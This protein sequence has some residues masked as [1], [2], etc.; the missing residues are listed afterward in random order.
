[1]NGLGFLEH[2]G[3]D[4]VQFVDLPEPV[5]GPGEVRVR[6]KAASFNHLDLFTLEGI[7]GVD[8][9]RPHVLGSD[10][11]GVVDRLG[12]GSD[13]PTEGSRVLLNPGLWDG[14]CEACRKGEES[15]C[16]NY[17]ILGEHTQGTATDLVVVPERNV[18]PI[19]ER[20]TFEQASAAPLVF[21]TAWRA[22][23]TVAR[24]VPGESC[25]IIGAGG[26]VSTAAVQVAR[27]LGARVVVATRSEEKA[28]QVRRQGGAEALVFGPEAP[29]ERV[30][31][32]WSEKKGVD[33]IFDS[34]GQPTVGRSLLATARSGRI[35][36]VGATAG[37]K[38]EIDLRTL[39][40][41]QASLRGSTMA[42]AAEFRAVLAEL[43]RGTLRPV[44]DSIFPFQ[45]G[46]DA[47][48]RLADPRLFGKVVLTLP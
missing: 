12:P 33:V 44:V 47:L 2:G 30:L 4:R 23:A 17:R 27:R 13:A 3:L 31:W 38:V 34:V 36:V 28:A 7:P 35:V 5:P 10:G 25:A 19:P 43:D 48:A 22:L 39:F 46:R 15:L 16:R 37:P 24:L 9:S 29:L 26:G 41:R 11:A 14:S 40:W 20:L 6:I 18:H 8:I 42:G 32:G 45:Q 21:Q 1:M